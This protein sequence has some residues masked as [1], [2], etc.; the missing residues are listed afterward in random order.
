[1]L[2]E[3]DQSFFWLE[4]AYRERSPLMEFIKEDANFDN[5]RADPRYRELV[6]KIGM[7]R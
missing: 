4:Q 1:L 6:T 7:D 2:N 3:K 5:L